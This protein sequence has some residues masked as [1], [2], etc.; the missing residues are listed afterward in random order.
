MRNVMSSG[1]RSPEGSKGERPAQ[2][3]G[4]MVA[5][6]SDF[7]AAEQHASPRPFPF[8]AFQSARSQGALHHF[9]PALRGGHPIMKAPIPI[10]SSALSVVVAGLAA[11]S[12]LTPAIA[13]SAAD[14]SI[15]Q[16]L[17]VIDRV[18]QSGAFKP[19]WPSLEK[20]QVPEW[21][22]DAKFGIFIHWGVY[23]VPA[24]KNEWY[25]REMYDKDSKVHQHHLIAW[26]H[27]KD[28]GY[29][30]FIPMFRAE[31][32]DPAAWVKLFKEAGARYVVPVAEHHD[33]FAMYDT[34]LSEWNAVKMGPKRDIV[35]EIAQAAR[36]AGLVFG[37][38]THR[39]E[40][41]WFFDEGT[42]Y[43]TDVTDPRYAGLYAPARPRADKEKGEKQEQPDQAFLDDWLARTCELVDKYQPQLVWFDWWIEEPA[44]EPYRKK[45]GAFYYN[46]GR[47]WNKGVALNYK[48][49][50]FPDRAGVLD[51][52]RAQLAEIR[53]FFWQTDTSVSKAWWGYTTLKDYKPV[54]MLVGDLVD[55]VSK[56]GT[57][58]LN[59]GP[60]ADG[61]IPEEQ[62]DILRGIGRWLW[63]N[64]EAIYGTRPYQIY[65]EGGA[66]IE[67]HM[68]ESKRRPYNSKDLRYT[69]KGDQLYLAA[70]V[71]P[72]DDQ[73]RVVSLADQNV[74]AVSLLGYSGKLDWKHDRT[75]GL[76]VKL[77]ASH[78]YKVV[79]VLK[80]DRR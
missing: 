14:G 2:R 39:A 43:E 7:E 33:G 45:F 65:G 72:E 59:I 38:S 4:K 22:Q 77:P 56:N 23:T 76:T 28:F 30:D 71:W 15:K 34:Q 35:G 21:Y 18:A 53:P 73:M 13:A 26:G 69:T 5:L 57:L 48:F 60:R 47:E 51:I 24:F 25:P 50:A 58:L 41:W 19:D 54:E 40:H 63:T 79:P 36:E 62:Q 74:N 37:L 29:K 42:K 27:P 6:I 31:K 75:N 11:A 44:F 1:R 17:A 78:H 61:T 8:K 20:Y 46:R 67:G 64:G 10:L 32:F 3:P 12:A 80:I 55:I 9:I 68:S 66:L 52:E 16:R 49:G 70:L